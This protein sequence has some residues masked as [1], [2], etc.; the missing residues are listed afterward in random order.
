MDQHS[1][2]PFHKRWPYLRGGKLLQSLFMPENVEAVSEVYAVPGHLAVLLHSSTQLCLFDAVPEALRSA[3]DSPKDSTLVLEQLM[4]KHSLAPALKQA[5]GRCPIDRLWFEGTSFSSPSASSPNNSSSSPSSS[6]ADNNFGAFSSLSSSPSAPSAAEGI[7]RSPLRLFAAQEDGYLHC[8]LWQARRYQWKSLGKV[9][10]PPT[11]D[12]IAF[13]PSDTSSK[14]MKATTTTTATTAMEMVARAVSNVCSSGSYTSR[15]HQLL[16]WCERY[17][18][19][20]HLQHSHRAEG[21]ED[22][23]S[24]DEGGESNGGG[25]E[26]G[27]FWL[28]ERKWRNRFC[29]CELSF[30]RTGSNEDHEEEEEE[31]EPDRSA[32]QD[33]DELSAEGG[34]IVVNETGKENKNGRRDKQTNRQLRRQ[35]HKT[36]TRAE[37]EDEKE[38]MFMRLGTPTFASTLSEDVER[39]FLVN[40]GLWMMT[41]TT[42][43]FWSFHLR[44][45]ISRPLPCERTRNKPFVMAVSTHNVTREPV[46][47]DSFGTLYL[48]CV[49][50]QQKPSVGTQARTAVT[51]SSRAGLAIAL[52]PLIRCEGLFSLASANSASSTAT[53]KGNESLPAVQAMFLDRQTAGIILVGSGECRLFDLYSGSFLG[54]IPVPGVSIVSRSTLTSPRGLEVQLGQN[55][56]GSLGEDGETSF[57]PSH[58]QFPK[59]WKHGMVGDAASEGTVLVGLWN[60][61]GMWTFDSPPI[62]KQAERLASH[63]ERQKKKEGK[64]E[65]LRQAG[66]LCKDWGQERLRLKY[67]FDEAMA[68]RVSDE[69]QQ[70]A[71]MKTAR[72]DA[73]PAEV[74]EHRSQRLQEICAE[75]IPYLQ[76]PALVIGL[77]SSSSIHRVFIMQELEKFLD[78][79]TPL[80]KPSGQKMP[81]VDRFSEVILGTE[82]E[83]VRNRTIFHYYTPLNDK[84]CPLLLEYLRLSKQLDLSAS[85]DTSVPAPSSFLDS[86]LSCHKTSVPPFGHIPNPLHLFHSIETAEELNRLSRTDLEFLEHSGLASLLLSKLLLLLLPGFEEECLRCSSSFTSTSSPSNTN[87]LSFIIVDPFGSTGRTCCLSAPHPLLLHTGECMESCFITATQQHSLDL[88]QNNTNSTHSSAS[89]SSSSSSSPATRHHL[90][91][92]YHSH[93]KRSHE[94]PF[95]ELMCRLFYAEKPLLL[96]LFVRLIAAAMPLRDLIEQQVLRKPLDKEKNRSSQLTSPLQHNIIAPAK[97][98]LQQRQLEEVPPQMALSFR[99]MCCKRAL[100]TLPPLLLEQHVG[101]E[102]GSG[103]AVAEQWIDARVALLCDSGEAVSALQLLLQL[104]YWDKSLTLAT[105]LLSNGTTPTIEKEANL[106]GEKGEEGECAEVFHVLLRGALTMAEQRDGCKGSMTSRKQALDACWRLMPQHFNSFQLFKVLRS[107][108][109]PPSA[110]DVLMQPKSSLPLNAMFVLEHESHTQAASSPTALVY[111]VNDFRSQFVALLQRG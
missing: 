93:D 55:L 90:P 96:P 63:Q 84:L 51:P 11:R 23:T 81:Q 100:L 10:L 87:E 72:G 5:Y 12:F 3:L 85:S 82:T 29:W 56:E 69:Q 89:L 74:E 110:V 43:H 8:W 13:S 28:A 92:H 86:S 4:K 73:K 108:N 31:D 32:I 52:H 53:P 59:L 19:L 60:T 44:R 36:K 2:Q 16:L 49:E 75:M 18:D 21:E 58:L 71:S 67:L 105:D 94:H 101:E 15:G 99:R 66:L 62:T 9:L 91:Y 39:T 48:C 104:G 40:D 103:K 38:A 7:R 83:R 77:L 20:R 106:N 79:M 24:N 35:R 42:L 1:F 14:Q 109:N 34:V 88:A 64:A 37:L 80:P 45:L 107:A 25:S 111:C 46:L 68:L 98:L 27:D 70:A 61:A 76:N 33:D 22:K 78:K 41:A 57:M 95:F 50:Q 26:D 6:F 65:G 97:A 54:S 17:T 47:L 102:E 30:E